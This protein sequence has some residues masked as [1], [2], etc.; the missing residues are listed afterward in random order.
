MMTCDV[1]VCVIKLVSSQQSHVNVTR[2]TYRAFDIIHQCVVVQER[3]S[4][5]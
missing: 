1:A 3:T 5:C 4:L 2:R